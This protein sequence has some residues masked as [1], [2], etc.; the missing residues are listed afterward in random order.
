MPFAYKTVAAEDGSELL[1]ETRKKYS[2]SEDIEQVQKAFGS[3]NT[4]APLKYT[5]SNDLQN[6]YHELR[7]IS[8][9]Y[10][11][12]I[13]Q[14][15]GQLIFEQ[16]RQLL[17]CVKEVKRRQRRR[18]SLLVK[19][20][21]SLNNRT[22]LSKFSEKPFHCVRCSKDFSILSNFALHV[23]SHSGEKP[24]KCNLCSK[25]F[26][27]KYHRNRHHLIHERPFKCSQCTKSYASKQ[28]LIR[29]QRNSHLKC[30]HCSRV[31]AKKSELNKHINAR[32]GF[33][34]AQVYRC[35]FCFK[36]FVRKFHLQRHRRVHTHEKPFKCSQCPRAFSRQDNLKKH[37]LLHDDDIAGINKNAGLT[38]TNILTLFQARSF[39]K[40]T[41]QRAPR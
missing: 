32:K 35:E 9:E 8:R 18:V 21:Q 4:T 27:T 15:V 13:Y 1:A 26:S 11:S 3:A 38:D 20:I 7:K 37:I 39:Q 5:P 2:R 34:R 31:F 25:M 29:H 33:A 10:H 12:W 6:S 40:F 41:G 19:K 22:T 17:I 30:S 24:F 16:N 14:Y 28:H 23:R 36:T